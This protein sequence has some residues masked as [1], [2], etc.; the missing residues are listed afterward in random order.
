MRSASRRSR[1]L[2]AVGL[3]RVVVGSSSDM[4]GPDR[5]VT[6]L[7]PSSSGFAV[8]GFEAFLAPGRARR[9][10]S[11]FDRPDT[12]DRPIGSSRST[13][14]GAALGF[15]RASRIRRPAPLADGAAADEAPG[16]AQGPGPLSGPTDGPH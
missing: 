15:T 9:D 16:A 3:E 12:T 7:L 1:Q 2:G 8:R 5:G 13:S 11:G 10:A 4:A 6:V 14:G